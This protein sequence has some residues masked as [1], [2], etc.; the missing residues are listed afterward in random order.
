MNGTGGT[1]PGPTESPAPE[2]LGATRIAGAPAGEREAE[3]S[4]GTYKLM[5]RLGGGGMGQIYL[6]VQPSVGRQVAVKVLPP[7][8]LEGSDAVAR[9]DREV[10]VLGQLSHPHICPVLEAGLDGGTHFYVMEYLRGL[11][12]ARVLKTQRMDARR[13]AAI[14]AQVARALQF[15]HERG[16]VHRDVKPQNV[17]LVR[18]GRPRALGGSAPA[19]S[20]VSGLLRRFFPGSRAKGA[21]SGALPAP[22]WTDTASTD[23]TIPS[24]DWEDHAYLIDFGLAREASGATSGLT[25]SGQVIG[26]P[27]YMAPE[28]ARGD[29]RAVDARTDVYSLGAT[30]YE[31][32]TLQAPFTGESVGE[33]V[34]KV[35]YEEALPARRLNPQLDREIETVVA[36][37][38]EKDPAR[39]YATAGEF[40][41]DLERWLAGE[42]I[43]ARPAGLARRAGR[44]I[45]RNPVASAALALTAA[46]TLAFFHFTF[47]P[48][49]LELQGDLAGPGEYAVLVEKPG[50]DEFQAKVVVRSRTAETLPVTLVSSTG[51][52]TVSTNPAGAEVLWDGT[53]LGRS[54]IER[55]VVRTGVHRIELRLADHDTIP[56]AVEIGPA[57]EKK[58][59]RALRHEEG[60]LTL[61][62]EPVGV[63]VRLAPAGGGPAIS[64]AAPAAE[65]R[66][67]T[68]RYSGTAKCLGHFPTS[69]EVEISAGRPTFRHLTLAPMQL[70]R[71]GGRSFADGHLADLDGDGD[72]D[73]L[74]TQ[75]SPPL[76]VAVEGSTGKELWSRAF[77]SI[78]ADGNTDVE[79]G[80]IDGDLEVEAIWVHPAGLTVLEGAT[81]RRKR[82]LPCRGL[83][84]A[85]I[86][87]DADGDGLAD[88]VLTTGEGTLMVRGTDGAVL[89]RTTGPGMPRST[90]YCA[91]L[92]DDG[93]DDLLGTSGGV[94]LALDGKTGELLWRGKETL[95][96]PPIAADWNG[97]GVDDAILQ[98]PR[99]D[100]IVLSGRDGSELHRLQVI[101]LMDARGMP[102]AG[103]LDGD[104][105][106]EV[107]C[108]GVTVISGKPDEPLRS[109]H[110]IEGWARAILLDVIGDGGREIIVLT[111]TRLVVL[112]AASLDPLL[113]IESPHGFAGAPMAGD[114]NG[115]GRQDIA[116][117]TGEGG[118]LACTLSPPPVVWKQRGV[119]YN[120]Q[121]A[122]ADG[123]PPERIFV[124]G[125]PTTLL[126]A[127]DGRIM[128]SWIGGDGGRSWT[129]GKR[130]I[131]FQTGVPSSTGMDLDRAEILWRGTPSKGLGDSAAFDLDGDGDLEVVWG[132]F[133]VE[134]ADLLTGAPVWEQKDFRKARFSSLL[135]LEH[136]L[137]IP[138]ADGYHELDP[139]TGREL[140]VV[141]TPGCPMSAQP[142]GKDLVFGTTS[143]HVRRVSARGG[144]PSESAVWDTAL[145]GALVAY[146][147]VFAGDRVLAATGTG[148]VASL[149]LATGRV[150]WRVRT[151]DPMGAAPAASDVTGDG[152]PDVAIPSTT[153]RVRLLDG[154]DGSELAQFFNGAESCWAESGWLELDGSPPEEYVYPCRDGFTY[155]LRLRPVAPDF[156][157]WSSFQTRA[158]WQT[159]RETLEARRRRGIADFV[160]REDWDGLLRQAAPDDSAWG[161]RAAAFAAEKLGRNDAA[162]L[163]AKRATECGCNRL[164]VGLLLAR[165]LPGAGGASAFAKALA[166][167]EPR[168]LEL[169]EP[170]VQDRALWAGAREE[171]LAR[172]GVERRI[173]GLAVFAKWADV[174]AEMA[175]ASADVDALPLALVA[176]RAAI[177][178]KRGA[179]ARRFLESPL[180][181]VATVEEAREVLRD[182]EAR[183]R[184][185]YDQGQSA[186][187]SGNARG[188]IS[189]FEDAV[190]LAPDSR[191]WLNA[192]AWA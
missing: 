110:Y 161:C 37:A 182:L 27:A 73:L 55:A 42:P 95:A 107:V 25:M 38:M 164:D 66:L 133:G 54:P 140:G 52:L 81:G 125:S 62:S 114:L 145:E 157:V 102:A 75:T 103:D 147:P 83:V 79:A 59:E 29:L 123:N 150:V 129:V 138:A 74:I 3:G 69:F 56:D 71:A 135:F 112:D 163:W 98:T 165:G 189:P 132:E 159:S 187:G 128:N 49:T 174:E 190:A 10:R 32:V 72:F 87:S 88:L 57:T 53:A 12:L 146:S 28:Q 120:T 22:S 9:F 131:A 11:D 154:V 116:I 173:L 162:T 179:E 160:L 176:A 139:R 167:A 5:R 172:A 158:A 8:A 180:K 171:F 121:G 186:L 94:P 168:D 45:A 80:D 191:E 118:L 39:R 2:D 169:L 130:W 101:T 35:I 15:A 115:D 60:L 137:W 93:V 4:L 16:I 156:E 7:G 105:R 148:E 177:R 43:R 48:G 19:S 134:A 84:H 127:R 153:G 6:A 192:L 41:D 144:A 89:W 122:F 97:D 96:C 65:I 63:Q 76:L 33:I 46:A 152:V 68:G 64:T 178:Q 20:R 91:R 61:T 31:L 58:V 143:G 170:T 126:A 183:A 117:V 70:W 26:T 149:D 77:D 151:G 124:P 13:A 44:R 82:E 30:L 90:C 51:W 92:N 119:G 99:Q 67:D 184:R 23:T 86:W 108:T 104:G 40:A 141:P 36:K 1:S 142:V 18:G 106:A 85:R 113:E 47:A 78:P 21:A 100:V 136:R 109:K 175:R 14:A 155:A 17:M 185:A 181:N 34:H 166:E 50:F 188:A 24:P 111:N